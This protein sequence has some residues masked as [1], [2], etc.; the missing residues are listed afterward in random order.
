MIKGKNSFKPAVRKFISHELSDNSMSYAFK[1]WNEELMKW[2]A[3]AM[4]LAIA[5]MAVMPAV[6]VGCAAYII[7]QWIQSH[8][9]GDK[10]PY[11]LRWLASGTGGFLAGNLAS[12]AIRIAVSGAVAGPAGAIGSLVVGLL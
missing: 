8:P 10:V 2:L 4:I 1:N 7:D 5:G 9:N 6:G 3:V 12:M 11:E